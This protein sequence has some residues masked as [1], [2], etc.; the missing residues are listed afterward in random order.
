VVPDDAGVDLIKQ[1]R[2]KF[3]D[4]IKL[5]MFQDICFGLKWL[6]KTL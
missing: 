4:E 6:L 2:P 3:T 5:V 1:F